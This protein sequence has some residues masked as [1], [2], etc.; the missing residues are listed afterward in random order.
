MLH[1][2]LPSNEPVPSDSNESGS[3][4]TYDDIDNTATLAERV[5]LMQ[6]TFSDTDFAD[7]AAEIFP[8]ESES[9]QAVLAAKFTIMTRKILDGDPE[10]IPTGISPD[11]YNAFAKALIARR[12]DSLKQA[13]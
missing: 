1:E 9:R 13:A 7:V 6:F 4:W 5:D 12:D 11:Q 10:I 8:D 2:S 3:A